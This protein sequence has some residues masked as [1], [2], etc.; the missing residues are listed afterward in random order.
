VDLADPAQHLDPG[1]QVL[2]ALLRDDAP[3]GVELHVVL[4]HQVAGADAVDRHAHVG[5]TGALDHHALR[6]GAGHGRV[7]A[8]Q[9]RGQIGHRRGPR[10]GR[11]WRIDEQAI[12]LLPIAAIEQ[13]RQRRDDQ[14]AQ[15]KQRPGQREGGVER[16]GPHAQA[17]VPVGLSQAPR[18][19]QAQV[20][21][22]AHHARMGQHA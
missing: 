12:D 22:I 18:S 15:P 16:Q 21:C 17:I 5:A 19:A 20:E 7:G 8:G 3:G 10:I 11:R 4:R 13:Q 9:Q 1:G 2:R 6:A 14:R